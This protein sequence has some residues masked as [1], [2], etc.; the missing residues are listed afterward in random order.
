M[1]GS[2]I[3]YNEPHNFKDDLES[4]I[5]IL[6]WVAL[7]YSKCSDSGKVAGFLISVLDPQPRTGPS[8]YT[9]KPEFL[10]GATFLRQVKFPGRPCFDNLL[11][12]LTNLFAVRYEL[13]P[14]HADINLANGLLHSLESRL[15]PN[16]KAMY[17]TLPAISFQRRSQGLSNHTLTINYFNEALRDRSL[18]PLEDCADSVLK[19]GCSNR[20][21]PVV[22]PNWDRFFRNHRLRFWL[23]LIGPVPVFLY[24]EI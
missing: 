13:P 19:S 7:T 16:L 2:L 15:N 17:E 4:T 5:Y 1:S 21:K 18:W 23:N 20:K 3:A 6:L 14:C 9:T 24:W 22:Q 8:T 12:K 10:R 11:L